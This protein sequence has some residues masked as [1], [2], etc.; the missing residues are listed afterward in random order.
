MLFKTPCVLVNVFPLTALPYRRTDLAIF[1]KYYSIVE[2]RILT[3]PEMLSSPVANSI[4]S[5]DYINNNSIPVDNTENE[6]KEVVIEMLDRLENKQII[7]KSN[8]VLQLNFKKLFLPHHHC[9]QFQSNIG[10]QFLKTPPI[11]L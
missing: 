11:V 4:Y 1:K 2:N 6:I 8:E 9:Y 3:I 5:T 10:N 7:D